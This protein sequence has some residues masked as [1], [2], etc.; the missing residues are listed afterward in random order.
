MEQCHVIAIVKV[1]WAPL[2]ALWE[3]SV[4]AD[5]MS[6]GVSA[7]DAKL[8]TMDFHPASVSTCSG[9]FSTWEDLSYLIL[10]FHC[11]GTLASL[12]FTRLDPGSGSSPVKMADWAILDLA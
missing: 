12:F 7:A 5:L 2:A 8:A 1:P 11:I 6:S 9:L 10:S 3:D 4:F